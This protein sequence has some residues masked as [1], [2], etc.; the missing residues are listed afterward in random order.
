[1]KFPDQFVPF[2]QTSRLSVV[3]KVTRVGLPW[4][5]HSYSP[6]YS[7]HLERLPLARLKLINNTAINCNPL[8]RTWVLR[9]IEWCV[10]KSR[11][12]C[13]ATISN[14]L[15]QHINLW[16]HSLPGLA[17]WLI[18]GSSP[19]YRHSLCTATAADL[20]ALRL[21][22]YHM[23]CENYGLSAHS[24]SDIQ[25]YVCF[26]MQSDA[27]GKKINVTLNCRNRTIKIN[28]WFCL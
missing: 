4:E 28:A 1:M 22:S 2:I 18:F 8:F 27:D 11:I 10:C 17:D 19:P 25:S 14:A 24:R 23:Y 12:L 20:H 9:P 13:T 21:E 7:L 6:P 15:L 5:A 26:F 3:C 16:P